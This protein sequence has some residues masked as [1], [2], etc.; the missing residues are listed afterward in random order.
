VARPQ[1][2]KILLEEQVDAFQVRPFSST[3]KANNKQEAYVTFRD[4]FDLNNAELLGVSF[5]QKKGQDAY[6]QIGSYY[7]KVQQR[8]NKLSFSASIAPGNYILRVGYLN[9]SKAAKDGTK[10]YSFIAMSIP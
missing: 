9:R 2:E 6:S 1:I 4:R 8:L 5:L 7:F 10:E 3:I